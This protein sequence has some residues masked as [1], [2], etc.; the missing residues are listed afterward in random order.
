MVIY[1]L[2]STLIAYHVNFVGILAAHA[3]RAPDLGFSVR[4][5]FVGDQAGTPFKT[6]VHFATAFSYCSLCSGRHFLSVYNL[7]LGRTTVK[8]SY[9]LA[10]GTKD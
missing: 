4:N 7:F 3:V 8:I 1:D 10:S 2:P 9:W 6:L 5:T